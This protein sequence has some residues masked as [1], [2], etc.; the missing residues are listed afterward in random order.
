[1]HTPLSCQSISV[2]YEGQEC[3]LT[4]TLDSGG[5]FALMLCAGA[6]YTAGKDLSTLGNELSETRSILVID[7]SCLLGAENTDFLS[8]VSCVEGALRLI[9]FHGDSPF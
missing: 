5:Q 4:C 1:M 6:G 7:N 9:S 3:H 8:S 2:G